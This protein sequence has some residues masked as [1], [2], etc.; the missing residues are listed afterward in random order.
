VKD[1]P[2]FRSSQVRL[3]SQASLWSRLDVLE[4][5]QDSVDYQSLHRQF[6][7]MLPLS[8]YQMDAL[9][10]WQILVFSSVV[11]YYYGQV[12]GFAIA[13][14]SFFSFCSPAIQGCSVNTR[15]QQPSFL[16]CQSLSSSWAS[17]IL[18][19]SQISL[20]TVIVML[21]SGYAAAMVIASQLT[22]TTRDRLI[23]IC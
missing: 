8:S 21:Q 18:S 6:T 13:A 20:R 22:M 12:D 2:L 15:R 17:S 1:I 11:V 7:M 5:Q 4:I 23:R 9:V 19:V 3:V 14:A 10:L 16:S